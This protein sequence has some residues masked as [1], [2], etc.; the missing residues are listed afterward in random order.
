MTMRVDRVVQLGPYATPLQAQA[1]DV[2]G[3]YAALCR[4]LLL[5]QAGTARKPRRRPCRAYVFQDR[6]VADQRRAGPVGADL[7][8]QPVFDRVPLRRPGGIVG[9]RDDQPELVRQLLQRYLPPPLAVV[10]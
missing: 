6:L 7:T 9:H 2:L 8:E 4:I 1:C 3:C 5:V 10:G